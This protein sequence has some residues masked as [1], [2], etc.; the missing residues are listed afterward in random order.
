MDENDWYDGKDQFDDRDWYEPQEIHRDRDRYERHE[1]KDESTRFNPKLDI[2]D[3]KGKI[4]PND[5]LDWLSAM[6][7]MFDYCDLSEH[8]KV[9]LVATKLW[10]HASFWW[11]NLKKQREK[12][13]RSKIIT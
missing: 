3:F 9:K 11:E 2:L 10:K 6:E 12:E 8:K 5:C 13:G 4:Q 7:R 1:R